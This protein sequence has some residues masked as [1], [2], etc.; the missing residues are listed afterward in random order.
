MSNAPFL[1]PMHCAPHKLSLIAN[2]LKGNSLFARVES[3][4]KSAHNWVAHSAM[5]SEQLKMWQG[6]LGTGGRKLQRVSDT[7]W[8]SVQGCLNTFRIEYPAIA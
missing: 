7:R 3:I 2:E 5:K 4:L 8:L 6:M 1:V